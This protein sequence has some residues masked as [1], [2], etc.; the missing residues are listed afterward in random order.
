[1]TD[2]YYDLWLEQNELLTEYEYEIA[3][4]EA[5]LEDTRRQ[6]ADLMTQILF[7]ATQDEAEEETLTVWKRN[8]P[9]KKKNWL[10]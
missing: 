10:D 7:E 3:F 2:G 1:M 4:L 6:L 8:K 5:S 9:H